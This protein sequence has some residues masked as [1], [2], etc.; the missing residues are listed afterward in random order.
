MQNLNKKYSNSVDAISSISLDIEF[1]QIYGIIGPNG[2]GKTT[3]FRIIAGEIAT[4]TGKVIVNDNG[5]IKD[6]NWIIF[7]IPILF[8]FTEFRND[9]SIVLGKFRYW[10]IVVHIFQSRFGTD[11][12]DK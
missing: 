8:V 6:I 4:D 11:A 1:G 3:L 7:V 12:G 5:V 10:R 2:A 9:K